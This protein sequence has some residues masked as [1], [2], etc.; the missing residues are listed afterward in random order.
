MAVPETMKAFQLVAAHTT[1]LRDVPVREPGP[2]QVL[3]KVAGAGLCHSDLHMI[4][5]AMEGFEPFTFG[6]ETAGWI[7]ALGAGVEHLE[8]G[9][10]RTTGAGF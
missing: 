7:E 9:A 2:G 3:I 6:H 8:L 10:A 4:H 5:A 1:E